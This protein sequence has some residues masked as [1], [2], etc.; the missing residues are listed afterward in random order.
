MI[1]RTG[2]VAKYIFGTK[3]MGRG[4]RG[5]VLGKKVTATESSGRVLT[6]SKMRAPTRD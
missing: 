3:E 4:G 1:Q 2:E 6:A 5:V